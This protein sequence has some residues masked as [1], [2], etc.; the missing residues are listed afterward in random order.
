ML[1]KSASKLARFVSGGLSGYSV[2]RI[3]VKANHES[4]TGSSDTGRKQISG[5]SVRQA[6]WVLI[7]ALVPS[8]LFTR[9]AA[10]HRLRLRSRVCPEKTVAPA[11]KAKCW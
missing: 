5:H 8:V 1:E 10:D 3:L 6:C 9:A 11:F 4:D 2:F 7:G